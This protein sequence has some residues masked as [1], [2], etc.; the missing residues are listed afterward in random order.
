MPKRTFSEA[1]RNIVPK[2]PCGKVST[3]GRVAAITVC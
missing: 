2:M 3:Y 1:V